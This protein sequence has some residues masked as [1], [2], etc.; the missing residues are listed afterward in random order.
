MLKYGY[1]DAGPTKLRGNLRFP[2]RGHGRQGFDRVFRHVDDAND[3]VV[4][5]S[6]YSAAFRFGD[7]P[8][9]LLRQTQ[10]GVQMSTEW[11]EFTIQ[12][13]I[14][15]PHPLSTNSLGWQLGQS[16][17]KRYLN[18]LNDQGQSFVYGLILK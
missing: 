11:S 15:G 16:G 18:V 4:L 14:T 8:V 3:F 17:F 12:R 2:G 9:D 1:L 5:E 7:D 6:K 13:M 10:H